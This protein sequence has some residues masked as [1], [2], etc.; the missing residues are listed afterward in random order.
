MY[1]SILVLTYSTYISLSFLDV[2]LCSGITVCD[3]DRTNKFFLT[4]LHCDVIHETPSPY[5]GSCDNTGFRC[6]EPRVAL[7]S[8]DRRIPKV[9]CSPIT[10]TL[11]FTFTICTG[12]GRRLHAPRLGALDGAAAGAAAGAGRPILSPLRRQPRGRHLRHHRRALPRVRFI[13]S[14]FK[15]Y[16]KLLICRLQFFIGF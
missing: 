13:S 1:H 14:C 10:T 16:V 11:V 8:Y 2:P 12:A 7:T 15:H 9:Q 5:S 4:L 3:I 6:G